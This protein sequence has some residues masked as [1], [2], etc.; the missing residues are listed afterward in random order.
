MTMIGLLIERNNDGKFIGVGK[1]SSSYEKKFGI[2]GQLIYPRGP[3]NLH[4]FAKHVC[5]RMSHFTA[6]RRAF[7]E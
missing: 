7:D 5:R 6:S 3:K 2:R 1:S 4:P